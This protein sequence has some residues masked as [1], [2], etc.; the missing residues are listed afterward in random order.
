[1]PIQG[2]AVILILK[3]G[4][5]KHQHYLWFLIILA[6]TLFTGSLF[7]FGKD[8][9]SNQQANLNGGGNYLG[10]VYT[11]YQTKGVFSP[12]NLQINVG[13]TVRF[14]NDGLTPMRVASDPHPEH[15]DLPGFDSVSEIP[16]QGIFS[17]TFSKRG[18]FDYHNE[19]KP[20]QKGTVIVK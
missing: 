15:S 11:V 20:E 17:F 7:Y 8:A 12:T 2:F 6:L 16:P 19:R 3:M 18:I 13:D 14:L 1:M 9:A 4:E 10:K 5:E